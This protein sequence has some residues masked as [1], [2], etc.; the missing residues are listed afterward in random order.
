MT[1]PVPH[2]DLTDDNRAVILR[3]TADTWATRCSELRLKP[4]S[5][6]RRAQLE[7]FLQGALAVL[8]STRVMNRDSAQH[9]ALAVA[10][11]RGE[12]VLQ[13]WGKAPEAAEPGPG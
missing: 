12:D 10:V 9:V 2:L 11:G 6:A 1:N 13:A 4:G 7:A 3:V 5:A 8:T